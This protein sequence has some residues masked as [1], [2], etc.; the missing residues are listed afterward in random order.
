MAVHGGQRKRQN[1][2]NE[3]SAVVKGSVRIEWVDRPTAPDRFNGEA[4]GNGGVSHVPR[5]A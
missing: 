1:N 4:G 3:V 5:L 2:Y